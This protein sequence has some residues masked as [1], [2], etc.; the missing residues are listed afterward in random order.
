M[1]NKNLLETVFVYDAE[2]NT[3]RACIVEYVQGD[4]PTFVKWIK[5]AKYHHTI[6][7]FLRDEFTKKNGKLLRPSQIDGLPKEW[8]L[9]KKPENKT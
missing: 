8:Y 4:K 9:K 3:H 6:P 7:D 5:P 2:K 1:K